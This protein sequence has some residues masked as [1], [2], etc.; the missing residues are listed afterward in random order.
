MKER[1]VALGGT[2]NV[3]SGELGTTI[4]VEIPLSATDPPGEA[5]GL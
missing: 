2:L 5:E 1:A 3:T 4:R